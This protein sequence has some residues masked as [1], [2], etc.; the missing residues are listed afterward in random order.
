MLKSRQNGICFVSWRIKRG[1]R[2]V[3]TVQRQSSA[4]QIRHTSNNSY[5]TPTNRMFST[6]IEI[7]CLFSLLLRPVIAVM[8]AI[9]SP[10]GE[11]AAKRLFA[12]W[13]ASQSG[14]LWVYQ[15]V[16]R[17]RSRRALGIAASDW[18]LKRISGEN[19]WRRIA[20]IGG[21]TDLLKCYVRGVWSHFKFISLFAYHCCTA[22]MAV[23]TAAPPL[24]PTLRFTL[25]S[26]SSAISRFH[27]VWQTSR[28]S[29]AFQSEKRFLQIISI[30]F[31]MA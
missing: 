4:E 16:E 12:H 25:L 17:S 26:L 8:A 1:S 5:Y 27:E 13:S 24:R 19:I 7:N 28:K 14:F 29:D 11:E 9:A 21:G 30:K 18:A 10:V 2:A 3:Q 22:V 6:G 31:W 23:M 20:G 15:L